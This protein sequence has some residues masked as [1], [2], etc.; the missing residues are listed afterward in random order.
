MEPGDSNDDE[1]SAT[2]LLASEIS[3]PVNS[4]TSL[5]VSEMPKMPRSPIAAAQTKAEEEDRPPPVGTTPWTMASM[6]LSCVA[7]LKERRGEE[8]GEERRFTNERRSHL[9]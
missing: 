8:R 6:P 4:A 1:N 3:A 5:L 7:G 2:S 9:W